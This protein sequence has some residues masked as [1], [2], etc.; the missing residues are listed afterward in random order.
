MINYNLPKAVMSTL[1]VL[2]AAWS[3]SAQAQTY[4]TRPITVIVPVQPGATHDAFIRLISPK[5]SAAL[6]QPIVVENR[7]FDTFSSFIAFS[8]SPS[9]ASS[10]LLYDSAVSMIVIFSR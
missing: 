6:G 3:A 1:V 9:T 8:V 5:L 2:A 7:V 10:T 4:P